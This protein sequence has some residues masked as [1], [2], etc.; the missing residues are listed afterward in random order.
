M[1]FNGLS[2]IEVHTEYIHLVS[3]LTVIIDGVGY[4]RLMHSK[5]ND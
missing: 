2:S 4:L 1:N 3:E 5:Y